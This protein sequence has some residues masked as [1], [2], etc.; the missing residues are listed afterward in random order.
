MTW[1]SQNTNNEIRIKSYQKSQY[2]YV[3][4]FFEVIC[5]KVER[6]FL[7]KVNGEL[8]GGEEIVL[9]VTRQWQKIC[10]VC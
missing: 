7:L 6:L 5:V 2:N 3:N 9:V 4:K 10:S 8:G 1:L